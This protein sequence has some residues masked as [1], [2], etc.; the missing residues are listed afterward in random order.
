MSE[1]TTNHY[2]WNQT[3]L[4]YAFARAEAI[5][6]DKLKIIFPERGHNT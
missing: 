5:Y 2:P 1:A 3:I 4:K 6:E